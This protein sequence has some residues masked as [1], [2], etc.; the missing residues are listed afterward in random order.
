ME[1]ANTQKV[2][3][4]AFRIVEEMSPLSTDGTWLEDHHRRGQALT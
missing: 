2:I 1:E 4:E 3:E